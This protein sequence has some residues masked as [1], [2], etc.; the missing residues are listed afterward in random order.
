MGP[1]NQGT[2]ATAQGPL[3]LEEVPSI[4]DVR[5][6]ADAFIFLHQTGGEWGVVRVRLCVRTRRVR[7]PNSESKLLS[8]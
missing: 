8:S 1:A 4:Y 3:D 5:G 2:K 7:L 6:A